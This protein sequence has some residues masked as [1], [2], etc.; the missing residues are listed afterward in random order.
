MFFCHI[1]ALVDSIISL[2][3]C[4]CWC[5]RA[6]FVSCV[7]S[8]FDVGLAPMYV[9][10]LYGLLVDF[11]DGGYLIYGY[12]LHGLFM[13]I[14]LWIVYMPWWFFH[15]LY[16]CVVALSVA[17]SCFSCLFFWMYIHNGPSRLMH[18]MFFFDTAM[19]NYILC[20]YSNAVFAVWGSARKS[21]PYIMVHNE[22]YWSSLGQSIRFTMCVVLYFRVPQLRILAVLL[23]SLCRCADIFGLIVST[24]GW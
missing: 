17:A 23:P 15:Y 19:M 22:S 13:L 20:S 12:L 11:A 16:T 6:T 8:C 3:Y 4:L 14:W 10:C 18:Q 5:L 7:L 2:A 21:L 24:H 9:Q 1:Y